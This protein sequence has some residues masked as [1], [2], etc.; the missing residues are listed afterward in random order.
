MCLLYTLSPAVPATDHHWST[1]IDPQLPNIMYL[2]YSTETSFPSTAKNQTWNLKCHIVV[3]MLLFLD[4]PISGKCWVY[5]SRSLHIAPRL[6]F[7]GLPNGSL[8]RWTHAKPHQKLQKP[9]TFQTCQ[10]STCTFCPGCSHLKS[11]DSW[12]CYKVIQVKA[13]SIGTH[14]Q[15][16]RTCKPPTSH[17][18]TIQNTE[19][20]FVGHDL[21]HI[22]NL[23]S[24]FSLVQR[25]TKA[26]FKDCL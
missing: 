6:Q 20:R 14:A 18:R 16:F 9:H 3:I 10:G 22:V 25:C 19:V 11:C 15:C 12:E 26:R 8:T 24:S 13:I 2:V 17:C 23:V 1:V 7:M 21:G 5:L 4:L